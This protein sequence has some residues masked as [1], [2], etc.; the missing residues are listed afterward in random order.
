MLTPLG[1]ITST[2]LFTIGAIS[3]T[4]SLVAGVASIVE[5]DS[6]ATFTQP[7]QSVYW[8]LWITSN[9]VIC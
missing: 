3:V 1:M 2:T 4:V 8:M 7:L 9:L 6:V 5:V